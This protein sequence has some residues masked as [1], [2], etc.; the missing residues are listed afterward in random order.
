MTVKNI[1]SQNI[2]RDLKI[3]MSDSKNLMESFIYLI[4]KNTRTKTVKIAGFGSFLYQLSPE[5][6]G[7]NPKTKESYIICARKK[8]KFKVSD[9]I[10]KA[11]N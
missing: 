7:R 2:K 1:I 10:K 6:T 11:I 8:L 4:K 9:K 5:R 3:S